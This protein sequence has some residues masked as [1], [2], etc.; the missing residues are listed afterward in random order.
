[1]AEF[2]DDDLDEAM[3]NVVNRIAQDVTRI[4]VKE[5]DKFRPGAGSRIPVLIAMEQVCLTV[6]AYVAL[7]DNVRVRGKTEAGREEFIQQ[8]IDLLH[9]ALSE[10]AKESLAGIEIPQVNPFAK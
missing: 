6:I 5:L 4:M 7:S 3:L 10:R 2:E 8:T 9:K 1:M